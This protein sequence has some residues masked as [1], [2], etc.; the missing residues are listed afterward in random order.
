MYR[1]EDAREAGILGVNAGSH[2]ALIQESGGFR[3]RELIDRRVANFA[4]G[5]ANQMA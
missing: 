2:C 3:S 4:K 1:F 5:R